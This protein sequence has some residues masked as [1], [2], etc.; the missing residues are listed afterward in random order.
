[1]PESPRVYLVTMPDGKIYQVT[2]PPDPLY[3]NPLTRSGLA[4]TGANH[5]SGGR[6][7]DGI[8]TALEVTT[9]D[10]SKVDLVVLS[11]CQTAQGDL[12]SGEGVYGLKRSFFLAGAASQMVTLWPVADK[13]TAVLSI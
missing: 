3:S 13:S 2:M 12:K 7:Q 9:M 11:A 1:M 4:F 10:L 8:L 5:K 6:G